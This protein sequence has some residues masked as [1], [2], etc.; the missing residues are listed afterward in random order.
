MH[1]KVCGSFRKINA[2]R[3]VQFTAM[4]VCCGLL[5]FQSPALAQSSEQIADIALDASV[6]DDPRF[7]FLLPPVGS[8]DKL[9]FGSQGILIQQTADAGKNA[10]HLGFELQ[11]NSKDHFLFQ[12]DFEC[13]QLAAPKTGWG[14]GLLIRFVTDDPQT[15]VLA[16]GYVATRKYKSAL[17]YTADHTDSPKQSYEFQPE[18]FKKGKM[19]I[20]RKGAE[21][22]ISIDESDVGSYRLLKKVACTLAPIKAVHVWCTRQRSG[23]TPAQYLLKRVQWIGDSYFSQP[24]PR[25]PFVTWQRVRSLLFWSALLAGVAY[26]V[27]GVRSGKIP[28]HRQ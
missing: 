4:L 17:C 6:Q 25:A 1:S 26:V 2:L 13:P 22:F 18:V 3:Q 11:A 20:E 8:K 23:N 28:I 19:L 15:P 21:L 27:Q 12:I 16:V 7:E 24:P 10:Q 5:T 14:Q 9:E